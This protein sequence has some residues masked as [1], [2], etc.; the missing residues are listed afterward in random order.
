MFAAKTKKF[1]VSDDNKVELSSQ[2][3]EKLNVRINLP[4]LPQISVPKTP[5]VHESPLKSLKSFNSRIYLIASPKTKG[6]ARV[7]R[8]QFDPIYQ[9]A[10]ESLS[11][12]SIDISQ[13]LEIDTKDYEYDDKININSDEVNRWKLLSKYIHLRHI[14]WIDKFVERVILYKQEIQMKV[15]E[16]KETNLTNSVLK[17]FKLKLPNDEDKEVLTLNS[18][19]KCD[20]DDSRMKYCYYC[21]KL[22]NKNMQRIICEKCNIVVHLNCLLKNYNGVPNISNHLLSE[23]GL[24]VQSYICLQCEDEVSVDCIF[25]FCL[26][27]CLL[28]GFF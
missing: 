6:I 1:D 26:F 16:T 2:N 14:K 27:A 25:Y 28:I 3:I 12:F 11:R 13:E 10:L 15:N 18:L 20:D 22:V 21:W 19:D 5:S 4:P 7:E 17:K 24:P 9:S 8:E 23:N